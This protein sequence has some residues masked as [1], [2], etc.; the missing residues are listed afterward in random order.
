MALA[1]PRRGWRG[2]GGGVGRLGAMRRNTRAHDSAPRWDVARPESRDGTCAR[3][4]VRS[5]A[6]CDAAG[7]SLLVANSAL[8]RRVGRAC[9]VAACVSAHGTEPPAPPPGHGTR[10]RFAA[11]QLSR[12]RAASSRLRR[13]IRPKSTPQ[14]RTPCPPHAAARPAVVCASAGMFRLSALRRC[15]GGAPEQ[16]PGPDRRNHTN[17]PAHAAAGLLTP[18]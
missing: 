2:S 11:T 13:R 8:R 17:A 18:A 5:V 3:R 16:S 7:G 10:P 4:R 15:R 9:E 6:T 12:Y 14:P 1:G